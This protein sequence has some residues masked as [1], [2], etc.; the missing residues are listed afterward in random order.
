MAAAAAKSVSRLPGMRLLTT[1]R[2]GASGAGTV[3]IRGET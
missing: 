1:T 2:V 3:L